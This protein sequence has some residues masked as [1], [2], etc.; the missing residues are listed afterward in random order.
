[1]CDMP[2]SQY[3]TGPTDMRDICLARK[4]HRFERYLFSEYLSYPTDV[5]H[6]YYA[7]I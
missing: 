2:L 1:M 6:A 4:N 5:R 3:L 7:N